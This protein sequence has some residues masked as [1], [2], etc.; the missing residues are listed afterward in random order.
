MSYG[1]FLSYLD[2]NKLTASPKDVIVPEAKH[3]H[4]HEHAHAPHAHVK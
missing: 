3:D 2:K 1:A 4:G